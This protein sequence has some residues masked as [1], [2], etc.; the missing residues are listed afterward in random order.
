[1]TKDFSTT[2]DIAREL[3]NIADYEATKSSCKN[4]KVGAL[5]FNYITGEVMAQGHND[6]TTPCL[7]CTKKDFKWKQDGCSSIHAEVNTIFNYFSKYG[8]REKLKNIMMIC[9]HAPCDQCVKYLIKFGIQL[10][11]Y[12]KLYTCDYKQWEGQIKVEKFF[13]KGEKEK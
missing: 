8:Y 1:M 10:I 4:K 3:I 12:N 9:T 2:Y 13:R 11:L 6:S 5:L 7:T